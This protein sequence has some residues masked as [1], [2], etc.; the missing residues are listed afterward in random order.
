M[1]VFFGVLCLS[2]VYASVAPN[3]V[4]GY[5][6]ESYA[7]KWYQIAN[8]PQFYEFAC[9][10]CV[11]ATYTL[12]SD[13]TIDVA[14]TCRKSLKSSPTTVRAKA[15]IKDASQPA[16]L[17]V[18]FAGL[19]PASYWIV[20]L[21]PKEN[22]AYSWALVSNND[23]TSCYILARTPTISSDVQTMVFEAMAKNKLDNSTLKFTNQQDCW[24]NTT[25]ETTQLLLKK[26]P[27]VGGPTHA[28]C[29][30]TFTFPDTTCAAVINGLSIAAKTMSGLPPSGCGKR[31]PPI[32][33]FCGY[34]QTGATA[35]SWS[36]KH[37]TASGKYT[38]DL[39]FTMTTAG[40]GCSVAG[41]STS[42]TWYALLD[43]GVNYCNLHN[44]VA[45][46]KFTNTEQTSSAVC[47]QYKSAKCNRY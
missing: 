47:T 43:S 44:L 5:D 34:T 6:V 12:N 33:S 27:L 36:G 21:G 23:G 11:T 37:V 13:K 40:S 1:Q 38:D 26:L 14:N 35:N 32:D 31:F 18:L 16:K 2:V 22:N 39:T 10:Q 15:S 7:G 45:E 17:T 28:S 46:T 19:F 20:A 25:Q 8:Y 24:S 42:E 3:V 29:K 4:S 30:A 41:F 9:K